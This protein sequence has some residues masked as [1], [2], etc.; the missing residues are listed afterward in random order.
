MNTTG[1]LYMLMMAATPSD[2]DVENHA[3]QIN[4]ATSIEDCRDMLTTYTTTNHMWCQPIN[5]NITP[6]DRSQYK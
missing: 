3:T 4:G 1:F 2:M 5:Y 6:L